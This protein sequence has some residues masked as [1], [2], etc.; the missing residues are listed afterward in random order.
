MIAPE[1]APPPLALASLRR[2]FA[3]LL[4]ELLLLVALLFVVS[5][6][7]L[8]LVTPGHAGTAQ[9][10]TVPA[11]PQRAAMACLLFAVLALYFTWCWSDGRRTLP[12]KTWKLRLVDA[13]ARDLP[14]RTALLRYLCAWIGPLL[15]IGASA[16]LATVGFGAHAAWLVLFNWLWAFVDRDRQFLH[17]RLAGT[18]LVLRP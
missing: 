6:A 15:A 17:D 3:A 7:L 1:A 18:R 11:L 9:S 2:R 14:R 13:Q 16:A 12:M 8:P 5:F 10:L 4:Y